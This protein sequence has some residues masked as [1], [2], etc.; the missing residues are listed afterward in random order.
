MSYDINMVASLGTRRSQ[1]LR[2]KGVKVWGFI[3]YP[4]N[5][6]LVKF[7]GTMNAICYMDL[8]DDHLR[9]AVPQEEDPAYELI[10]MQNGAKYHSSSD[11]TNY[12]RQRVD[13]L[14]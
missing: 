7:E 13:V 2:L 5:R 6:G 12:L 14:S 3:S 1:T 4:G 11:V 9:E 10:L 8:L